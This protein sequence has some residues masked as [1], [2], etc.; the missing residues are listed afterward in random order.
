[1]TESQK[2]S[3]AIAEE[4]ALTDKAGWDYLKAFPVSRQRRKSMM[5]DKWVVHLYSGPGRGV[6]PVLKELDGGRVLLEVDITRSKAFDVGKFGGVYRG[7]LWAAATGRV[8]GIIGA[9]PSRS[10]SD[11]PLVLKQLWLILRLVAKAAAEFPVFAAIETE[12]L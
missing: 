5:A 9:L 12:A 11:T 10:S 4:I 1:M 2:A 3:L 8:A 6:D 7:L